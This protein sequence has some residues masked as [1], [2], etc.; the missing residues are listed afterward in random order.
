MWGWGGC[1]SGWVVGGAMVVRMGQKQGK[2]GEGGD[3]E[4]WG[5]DG[6]G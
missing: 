2:D 4:F 3:D 1:R 5:K 6:M